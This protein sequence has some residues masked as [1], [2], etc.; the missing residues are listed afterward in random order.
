MAQ[1]WS[2]AGRWLRR[3]LDW[4]RK[5]IQKERIN[6][7]LNRALSLEI[8][9]EGENGGRIMEDA[10]KMKTK[11]RHWDIS[12][13]GKYGQMRWRKLLLVKLIRE[14][15]SLPF[16]ATT[17]L[18]RFSLC[19]SLLVKPALN[20][21]TSTVNLSW[22]RPWASLCSCFS[23]PLIPRL[24]VQLLKVKACVML[25]V[26]SH[27]PHFSRARVKVRWVDRCRAER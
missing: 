6:H 3:N 16:L 21:L 20:S 18:P 12:C 2:A 19:E 24:L 11:P 23:H 4:G 17:S 25:L 10:S 8:S 7:Q 22:S 13:L 1:N 26:S 27:T 9:D 5:G 14:E 15:I